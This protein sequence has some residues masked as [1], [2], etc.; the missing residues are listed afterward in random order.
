MALAADSVQP[1]A[2]ITAWQTDAVAIA[3]LVLEVLIA[4]GYLAAVARARS[5]GRHRP[6]G[7]TAAFMAGLIVLVLSLQSGFASYDDDVAWVH[8]LQHVL[9]MSIAPPLLALGAPVLLCLQVMPTKGARRLMAFLHHPAIR[10]L[11]GPKASLHVPLDYY[12]VMALYLFTPAH[13]WGARYAAVHVGTHVVFLVCGLLFWVP[14]VGLDATGWR[15]SYRSRLAMVA[16]GVPVSAAIAAVDG[17]WSLF[18][19]T[20]VATLLGIGLVVARR[21]YRVARSPGRDVRPLVAA[22]SPVRP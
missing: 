19:A 9:V 13:Q 10:V 3:G 18:V 7:S 14:I 17:S 6:A 1:H 12:A 16:V 2:F 11:C 5:R 22:V 4:V 15:P 21:D 8:N 20:E